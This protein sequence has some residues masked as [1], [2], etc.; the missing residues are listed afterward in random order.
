MKRLEQVVGNH[1]FNP[2]FQADVRQLLI[3]QQIVLPH[4]NDSRRLEHIQGRLHLRGLLDQPYRN[5]L[6]FLVV[7]LRSGSQDAHHFIF[8]TF[9][10]SDK[11][12]FQE[13]GVQLAHQRNPLAPGRRERGNGFAGIEVF[14][15]SSSADARHAAPDQDQEGDDEIENGANDMPL[16]IRGPEKNVKEA[17]QHAGQQDGRHQLLQVLH[18]REPDQGLVNAGPPEH[19]ARDSEIEEEGYPHVLVHPVTLVNPFP[20][21]AGQQRDQ[22]GKPQIQQEDEFPAGIQQIMPGVIEEF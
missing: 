9:Q 3:S 4:K 22:G 1:Q 6:D 16:V 11:G 13:A 20:V 19:G 7:R 8:L 21:I 18:G 12:G 10:A 5:L 17:Q 2:L 15:P 14:Q